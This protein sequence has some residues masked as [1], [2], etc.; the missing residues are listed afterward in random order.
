MYYLRVA[1]LR[2][3]SRHKNTS[4]SR[5]ASEPCSPSLTLLRPVGVGLG[6]LVLEFYRLLSLALSFLGVSLSGKLGF[7][8]SLRRALSLLPMV[9]GS[10]ASVSYTH[11]RAHE[12]KANLVC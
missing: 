9:G 5:R 10:F 11:L 12:T 8:R 7:T 2:V 4:S 1:G 6:S 3:S